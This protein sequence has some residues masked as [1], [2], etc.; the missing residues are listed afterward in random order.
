M[1][2]FCLLPGLVLLASCGSDDG[3]NDEPP[4]DDTVTIQMRNLDGAQYRLWEGTFDPVSDS[5]QYTPVWNPTAI[6]PSNAFVQVDIFL[7]P[8]AA[9]AKHYLLLYNLNQ[10]LIFASTEF[11]K[12]P[13]P[14]TIAIQLAGGTIQFIGVQPI[15]P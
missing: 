10:K 8:T 1:I 9:D 5:W 14:L 13:G 11:V 15:V 12:G 3:P 4:L 2:R 7:P 6:G